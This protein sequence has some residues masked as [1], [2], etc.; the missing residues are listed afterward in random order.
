MGTVPKLGD[1]RGWHVRFGRELNAT[2]DRA[3]FERRTRASAQTLPVIEGKHLEPFRVRVDRTSHAI[4][5][6]AAAQLLDAETTFSRP[7][8]AYRDVASATNRLTL[9]AAILPEQTVST[10][11]VFCLKTIIDSRAQHCLLALLNSLV[12]NY[13]V[14]LQVTTHVTVS[15]MARLPVPKPERGSAD[16]RALVT[17]ARELGQAGIEHNVDTYAEL[18]A[19]VARLY[20]LTREQYTHVVSTFPLLPVDLRERCVAAYGETRRLGGDNAPR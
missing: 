20:G 12:A 16:R 7:R 6:R 10:H 3:H 15:L 11:T 13:L 18:N 14:R 17:L 19:I 9:I 8:L 4:A 5:A 2:D 1:P